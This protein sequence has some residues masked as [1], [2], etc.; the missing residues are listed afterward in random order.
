MPNS[1]Q[2]ITKRAHKKREE[3]MK[4]NRIK[5]LMKAR[6]GTLRQLDASGQLP[7]CVKQKR[8]PNG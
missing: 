7:V 2:R 6:V 8:L 3:R 5:S 4:R 1:K